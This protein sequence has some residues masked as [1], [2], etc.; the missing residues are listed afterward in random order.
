MDDPTDTY[1]AIGSILFIVLVCLTVVVRIL[2]GSI[3]INND[4]YH[5]LD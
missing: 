4:L 3:R 1:L 2:V 5:E